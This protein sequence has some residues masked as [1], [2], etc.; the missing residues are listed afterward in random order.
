MGDAVERV[1]VVGRR[2]KNPQLTAVPTVRELWRRGIVIHT[3]A[4]LSTG[5]WHFSTESGE[6]GRGFLYVDA[7][8]EGVTTHGQLDSLPNRR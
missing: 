5:K 2:V 7:S 1:L 8:A 4:L 6:S 3:I